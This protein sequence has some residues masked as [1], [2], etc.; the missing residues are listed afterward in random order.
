M[1]IGGETEVIQRL[2]PISAALAP[3]IGKIPRR[4]R[5]GRN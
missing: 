2:D 4:A 3:G 5:T 1:M